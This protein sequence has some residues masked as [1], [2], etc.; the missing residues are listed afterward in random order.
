[1]SPGA[2]LPGEF[3][4]VIDAASPCAAR[5]IIGTSGPLVLVC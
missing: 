2:A 5:A 4:G 3:D 1:M